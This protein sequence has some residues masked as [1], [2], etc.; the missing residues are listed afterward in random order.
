[1]M[2]DIGRGTWYNQK[3]FDL[4]I[5]CVGKGI[6]TVSLVYLART[7]LFGLYAIMGFEVLFPFLRYRPNKPNP[8]SRHPTNLDCPIKQVG[9]RSLS[10]VAQIQS[11]SA[12]MSQFI[13]SRNA[14]S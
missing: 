13:F 5:Q 12:S 3:S 4:Q 7:P 9:A 1:M 6:I 14:L 11:Q 8:K 2:I 10:S